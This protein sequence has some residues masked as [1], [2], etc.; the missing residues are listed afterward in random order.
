MKT[1]LAQEAEDFAASVKLSPDTPLMWEKCIRT[2][3]QLGYTAGANK[4]ISEAIE[5][6]RNDNSIITSEKR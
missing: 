3:L 6:A 2:A 1:K 4:V 5:R